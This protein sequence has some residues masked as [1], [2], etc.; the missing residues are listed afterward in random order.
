[1]AAT[2]LDDIKRYQETF[3]QQQAE[4][5]QQQETRRKVLQEMVHV[6]GAYRYGLT[7]I[8]GLA[9]LSEAPDAIMPGN[10]S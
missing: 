3:Q 5:E 9:D 7:K 10:F 8:A 2:P 4:S 6:W 1:V